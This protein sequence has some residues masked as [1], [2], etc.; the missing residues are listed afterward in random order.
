MRVASPRGKN[1]MG[2]GIDGGVSDMS[3]VYV[4]GMETFTT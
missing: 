3:I 2:C 1:L 4:E